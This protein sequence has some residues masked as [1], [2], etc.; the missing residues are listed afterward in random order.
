MA[1]AKHKQQTVDAIYE[2]GTLRL[3]HPE[4]VELTEGEK[5][6]VTVTHQ[7]TPDEMTDLA[8]SV[9]SGLDE[10]EIAEIE[11]IAFDRSNFSGDKTL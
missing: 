8:A 11:K 9:Y 3:L 10:E 6:R 5:V 1:M 2:H 7:L 4:E